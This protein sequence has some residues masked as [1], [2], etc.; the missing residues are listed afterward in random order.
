[1]PLFLVPALALQRV[2][3]L[4]QRQRGLTDELTE[5]NDQFVDLNSAL[6]NANLS[7]AS[8]LVQTLEESDQ[9]TAGHSRAVANYARDIASKMG[10]DHARAGARV[11]VR[12]SA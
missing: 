11:S 9:Y 2:Y 7:F 1:M 4:Y 10:L 12:S 6:E 8:A 3:T 5:T